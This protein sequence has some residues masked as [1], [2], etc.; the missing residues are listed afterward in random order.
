MS[1]KL[2]NM[3]KYILR[4]L[5]YSVIT[6]FVIVFMIF[7]LSR[8][9]GDPVEAYVTPETPPEIVEVIRKKYH[10]DEPI[11]VL[12]WASRRSPPNVIPMVVENFSART[13]WAGRTHLPEVIRGRDTN[14]PIFWHANA[15]P[16]VKSLIIRMVNGYGKALFI[17]PILI[18]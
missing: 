8:L 17:Q 11:P 3:Q 12:F 18:R 2:S 6:I 10:L 16:Y 14:D 1:L 5:A 4:R 13:T 9:A 7:T 15:F